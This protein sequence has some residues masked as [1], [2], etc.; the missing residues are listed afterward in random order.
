VASGFALAGLLRPQAI[1]PNADTPTAA[2]AIFAMYA[3][4]RTIPLAIFVLVAIWRQW[5]Q[6]VL[7]L[8]LLAGVIQV[9]DGFVGLAQHDIGK[10]VGPFVIAVLQFWA[11]S[12]LWQKSAQT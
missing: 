11:V 8:G 12:V 9:L 1:L 6:T 5:S 7:I 2:S 10:T 3:A 4:A